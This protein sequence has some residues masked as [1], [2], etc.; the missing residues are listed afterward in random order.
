MASGIGRHEHALEIRAVGYVATREAMLA[1][2]LLSLSLVNIVG[3]ASLLYAG[4]PND[5][6][7]PGTGD[8]LGAAVL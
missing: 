8:G 7:F 1:V 5:C 4:K 6:G 2:S 3:R